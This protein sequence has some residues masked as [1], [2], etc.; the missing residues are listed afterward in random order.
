VQTEVE[1]EVRDPGVPRYRPH[2]AMAENAADGPTA[3]QRTM[4]QAKYNRLAAV[5]RF[6]M[7]AQP[8]G[9]SPHPVPCS[10]T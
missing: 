2:V 6:A 4:W 7:A 3:M 1:G 8:T 10:W 9:R 5:G